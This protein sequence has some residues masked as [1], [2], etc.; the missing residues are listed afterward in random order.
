VAEEAAG[1][2]VTVNRTSGINSSSPP[3]SLRN[4]LSIFSHW[5]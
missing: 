3:F 5:A 1:G 2:A 4:L